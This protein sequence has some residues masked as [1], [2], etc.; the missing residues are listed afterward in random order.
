MKKK[1]AYTFL[2]A[3]MAGGMSLGSAGAASAGHCVDEGPGHS[4][5]GTEHVQEHE[6]NEG[7]HR[8]YS[9]C[10]PDGKTNGND[11]S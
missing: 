9:S 4:Y 3:A 7:G 1:L 8:G 2:T 5:F 11:R 10:N 6:G